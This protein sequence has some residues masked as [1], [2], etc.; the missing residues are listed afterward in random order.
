VIVECQCEQ[1]VEVPDQPPAGAAYI[2]S[3]CYRPL[4]IT[5]T[6][7]VPAPGK[8]HRKRLQWL[9]GGALAVFLV[10]LCAVLFYYT[11]PSEVGPRRQ[12]VAAANAN[13]SGFPPTSQGDES[14]DIPSSAYSSAAEN[15]AKAREDEIVQ[16]DAGQ[17]G[18]F[19][20][21]S[22]YRHI[23]D[24]YFDGQ[25]PTIPVLWEPNLEEVGPLIAQGYVMQGLASS[26]PEMILLNP[27][28]RDNPAELQRVLCHEMIHVYLYTQHDMTTHHGPAFKKEWSRLM[29]AGA[30]QGIA[31]S[32]DDKLRLQARLQS[33][34]REL[35]SE[36]AQ[37]E[38]ANAA[39]DQYGSDVKQQKSELEQEHEE[40]NRRITQ[41]NQDR[42]GWPSR[43]EMDD[44]QARARALYERIA[45]FRTRVAAFNAQ[46]AR[47]NAESRRFNEEVARF[48]MMMDN[49]D[50]LDKNS[51]IPEQNELSP[52]E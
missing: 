52:R 37:L 19:E 9:G 21:E 34:S 17:S 10:A 32:E 45:D 41:A 49:P 27:R 14:Y 24:R 47:Y 15:P 44:Y 29:R 11:P 43:G 42:E 7:P 51:I 18:D 33:E 5:V 46:V 35:S 23:N 1:K 3:H 38:Q 20:L 16:E 50:G 39:L 28:N 12:S 8:H 48:R 4:P 40:L 26:H 36:S 2:C 13:S 25:L 31:G 6:E 30:F 22:K